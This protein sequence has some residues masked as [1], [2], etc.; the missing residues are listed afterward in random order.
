MTTRPDQI[1]KNLI[2]VKAHVETLRGRPEKARDLARLEALVRDT[3]FGLAYGSYDDELPHSK[4][5]Y[6]NE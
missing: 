6:C 4:K 1:R 2:G 3:E 5:E